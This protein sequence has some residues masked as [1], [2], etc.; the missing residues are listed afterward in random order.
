MYE[1][2]NST[3]GA[4]GM[5]ERGVVQ[6]VGPGWIQVSGRG[7]VSVT[8]DRASIRVAVETR[9]TS[10]ADAAEQNADMMNRVLGALR[11]TNAQGLELETTGYALTPEYRVSNDNRRSREIV[12][13]QVL[14]N[15]H[16][17]ISDVDGIGALMD[18]AIE[19]GANR[20]TSIS[21]F[22]SD[23]E[24]ARRE[25]LAAAVRSAR[26]EAEVMAAA[27]GY[28]LG[29]PLEVNGGA[30]RPFRAQAEGFAMATRAMD[31]P[32][33]VGDQSVTADV[34]IRFALGPETSG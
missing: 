23:V 25:A 27:L 24:D 33:E 28:E 4:T 16:A 19:A 9:A 18:A 1:V 13:Y 8:P 14:N 29:Q 12:A 17:T 26:E 15:V 20:V 22:A 31:T 32:I 10:A 5:S 3:V 11:N 30:Q 6:E 7:S 34:S 21:F 2:P